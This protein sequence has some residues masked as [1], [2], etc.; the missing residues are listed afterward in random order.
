MALRGR[1]L[2]FDRDLALKRAM[3]VFWSKGYEGTQLVDLTIAMGINPPS[4]YAAFGNKKA[5]FCE[6]VDLYIETIGSKS[7]KALNAAK[8]ARE[9]LKAMLKCT[10][11]VATSNESGGCLIVLGVVNNFPENHEVW[12]YLKKARSS[13]LAM[14]HARLERGVIEGDL[15]TNTDVKV[16]ASYFLGLTQTISFQAR[17]GA[18][19][20]ALTQLIKP[21]MAALPPHP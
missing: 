7:A 20:T 3:E 10:I 4:F 18:S 2:G 6:A 15:P 9:G 5:A 16:L 8:T 17:D 13:T 12:T 21:A 11:D 14:I 1:P 19:R